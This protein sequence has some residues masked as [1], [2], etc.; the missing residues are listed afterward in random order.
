MASNVLA[1]PITLKTRMLIMKSIG[2]KNSNNDHIELGRWQGMTAYWGYNEDYDEEGLLLIEK[3]RELGFYSGGEGLLALLYRVGSMGCYY[4][5]FR[6]NKWESIPMLSG[7]LS[8]VYEQ[9]GC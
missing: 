4:L 6:G 9:W 8:K 7:E 5:I 1:Q 3:E 2:S